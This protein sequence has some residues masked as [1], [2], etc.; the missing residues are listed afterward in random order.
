VACLTANYSAEARVTVQRT[1]ARA[2][3]GFYVSPGEILIFNNIG[4]FWQYFII[5]FDDLNR[6]VF[7]IDD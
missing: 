3:T 6:S 1:Q 5:Y 7:A 4:V 2:S